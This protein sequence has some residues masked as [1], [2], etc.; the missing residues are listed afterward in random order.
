M[1]KII[2]ISLFVL[3]T[4]IA[5]SQTEKPTYKVVAGDFEKNY[6]A[7]NFEA[8]FIM[9]S[10]D[11]KIV[12]PLDKLTPFLTNLK[13][14]AGN[15]IEREFITYKNGS[16]AVYKTKFERAI[17][18]LNI[19]ID[20]N[21]KINGFAVTPFK[22]NKLPKIERNIT[23]LILPFTDEW[24]VLWG[25]DTKE[26]NYHVISQAE[27]NAFDFVIKDKNGHIQT[28]NCLAGEY[29][30]Y[31]DISSLVGYENYNITQIPGEL[32]VNPSVGCNNRIR[33]SD[34]CSSSFTMADRPEIT[35]KLLFE[36]TN[37]LDVPIFIPN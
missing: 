19:S 4:N 20:N 32:F 30:V 37:K 13:S 6:S 5:F 12:V 21:S 35:T 3:I 9:F 25:G 34:L 18:A 27:K 16:V 31:A 17:Y 24:T 11:M 29:L 28:G 26:L 23:N 33:A 15:I 14:Q 1:K 22:D 2:S 8:I 7:N 10:S 36:Y